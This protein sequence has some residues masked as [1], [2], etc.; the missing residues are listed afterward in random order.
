MT[1]SITLTSTLEGMKFPDSFPVTDYD[2]VRV[3]MLKHAHGREWKVWAMGWKGLAYRYRTAVED[4]AAFAAAI[5]GPED[6]E[7]RFLQERTFF[8]LVVN[9]L[10]T[11]SCYSYGLYGL[12]ATAD[13]AAFPISTTRDLRMY[14]KNVLDKL[15]GP[16][17]PFQHELVTASLQACLNS[18]EFIE[19]TELRNALDHRGAP[20]RL[21]TMGQSDQIPD[22]LK[23]LPDLW[24]VNRNFDAPFSEKIIIWLAAEVG[25]LVSAAA[26]FA[27]SKI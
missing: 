24:T 14:P 22:D 4:Q 3:P 13:P 2:S 27:Q 23:D 10:S 12:I 20:G 15:A 9:S 21:I 19:L 25:K 11:I 26:T 7:K 5:T 18:V 8:G 1:P 16:G 17:S 6:A